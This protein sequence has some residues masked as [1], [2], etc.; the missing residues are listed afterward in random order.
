MLVIPSD[1]VSGDDAIDM[2]QIWVTEQFKGGRYAERIA[3][4][5]KI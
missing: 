5:D 4:I 3:M 2:I 1:F